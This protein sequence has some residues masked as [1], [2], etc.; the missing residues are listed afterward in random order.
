MISTQSPVLI[1]V[2]PLLAA[3]VISL[4]GAG[5]DR[6][7][8]GLLVAAMAGSCGAAVDTLR[9]VLR[10]GPLHYAVGGWPPP[11]GI[12]L[13][14][15]HLSA[16]VL[17]L[18]TGCGLLS[19][20]Y[21]L[22]PARREMPDRLHHYYT[23][24]CLLIT[25]LTGMVA[26]GDAF[27]LYVLLEISA[28]SSYAMLASG[29]GH[30]Y[31][32]TFKYIIM[33]TIGACFYLL[34]VGYLYIKTGTLNMADLFRLLG[35]PEMQQSVSIR[36]GFGLIVVG[37]WIK[38]AFFPLHGW[39]P[40]VYTR[41]A[42]ATGCLIAPLATKVAVYIMVRLL[43]SV[44][45]VGYVFRAVPWPSAVVWLASVAMVA[46]SVRALAQ[47]NLR[48]MLAYIIIAEVGY[49]V[50]GVWLGNPD[51]FIGAVYHILADGLM[52]L[53]LF[54]AVGAIV[55]RTG[56]GGIEA[57]EGI[58]QR[59]P[60]SAAVFFLGGMAVVGIPPTCGFFS[61]WYL[62][63]GGLAMGQHHYVGAL[64]FSSLVNAFI[65]YR[66]LERSWFGGLS[67]HG[68]GAAHGLSVKEAPVSMLV[69]MVLVA[70]AL[71]ITGLSTDAIVGKLIRF[72]IPAGL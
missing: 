11:I 47:T 17:V 15:D 4:L 7:S 58:W 56:K 25:G 59:M 42:T 31:Y 51:G 24:F 38:M 69:P 63:R 32:A 18:V 40:N 5:R 6:L 2:M 72:T 39:L 28:L 41:A 68:H 57:M 55:H 64:L 53:C 22:R 66:L 54:M 45:S 10:S 67:T 33:G 52:T 43:F 50:G 3:F 19:G 30:A 14:V 8:F 29:R 44:F 60:V 61:K 36:I 16:L 70:A 49:M 12:E 62:L 65:F 23:L 48:R 26:T 9:Q 21:S 13:V 35:Q 37:I 34:G 27:N 46:G 71:V 1:T 20:I